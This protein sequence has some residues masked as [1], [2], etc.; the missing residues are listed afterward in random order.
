MSYDAKKRIYTA[1][2][3]LSPKKPSKLW[4][5]IKDY[6]EKEEDSLDDFFEEVEK[7]VRVHKSL[8]VCESCEG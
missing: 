3:L 8:G 1:V 2:E 7:P 6:M 4:L 5:I